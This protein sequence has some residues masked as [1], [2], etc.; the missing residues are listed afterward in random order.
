MKRH[1]KALAT[2]RYHHKYLQ[3]LYIRQFSDQPNRS[4]QPISTRG[5]SGRE[6]GMDFDQP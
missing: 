6:G 1:W 3:E 2:F 5:S 4:D